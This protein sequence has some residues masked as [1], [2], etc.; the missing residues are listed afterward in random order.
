MRT[1]TR[2]AFTLSIA[3]AL[4]LADGAE[5]AAARWWQAVETDS[6]QAAL[7]EV[8]GP[9][10]DVTW[11]VPTQ[12]KQLKYAVQRD[13]ILGRDVLAV[14]G[15]RSMLLKGRTVYDS[16]AEVRCLVRLV[17]TEKRPSVACT[18]NVA[19]DMD[20]PRDPGI[21]LVLQAR[22]NSHFVTVSAFLPYK[23][24]S[25]R[26]NLKPYD[27]ISPALPQSI[28]L[29][30]EKD[31][32]DATA[33]EDKWIRVKCQTGADWVRVWVDDRLLVNVTEAQ[34]KVAREQHRE[35]ELVKITA[36]ED[37][38]SRT[39][40]LAAFKGQKLNK[41]V[42]PT[43]G[44]VQATLSPGSRLANLTVGPLPRSF[45]R[46]ETVALSGY[47]R[48]REL[49]G[50]KNT[51][52]AEGALPFGETVTVRGIPF[53][54]AD[55]SVT[56]GADHIDVGRSFLRQA[57]MQG[58]FP[59][60]L[61]RF[62]GAFYVDPTRIQLHLPN[63][64]YDSMYVVAAFDEERDSIPLLSA[65]FY[66]PSAGF[67]RVFEATVPSYRTERAN[68]DA[69]PVRLEDGRRAN[70]WLV[71]IPLDPA[72]LASFSDLGVLGLELTKKVRQYRSYPDPYIYGWHQGG[73]P[74]GV[75]V[76][77][78]TL[79][80]P[81]VHLT[82][83][84][85]PFGHVWPAG[86]RATYEVRLEN[87]TAEA[88]P[89]VPNAETTSYDGTETTK[90]SRTLTV[91]PNR[92]ARQRLYF[93]VK[94]FGIHTL[95]VTMKHGRKA[96]TEQRNFAHLAPD[97]RSVR[98]EPGKG[99][100]FGFWSYA[101]G[102]HTPPAK[103][104]FRV[105][106][107]A[108]A[109][110]YVHS[111]KV[112]EETQK[113]IFD[114]HNFQFG[115]SA[116]PIKPQWAWAADEKLDMDQYAAYATDAVDRIRKRQGDSPNIV[117]FF[118]EPHISQRVTAGNC[119]T[120]W[121]EK[122][123]EYTDD[124]RRHLRLFFNTAKAAAEGVHR[125]WPDAK[126][127]IPWGDPLFVLPL[128]RAGFP[129][130][131][132]DGS[133]LDMIG[134]ERL[135]EQQLHQ[136]STHRLYILREE[137]RK[138]GMDNPF[139]PYVE[140]IFVPTEPGACTWE[141]QAVRYHRW[142]L[143]SLAYGITHFFSGWFAFDCGD[144]YGAEH[145]GGCGIQRRIPYA[146]AKPAYAHFATMTRM[147]D[148][149]TF[150][151]WIP[152]GSLTTYCLRFSRAKGGPVYALWTLRGRRPVTLKLAKDG[153]VAVID[154]MDN[155]VKVASR[156][157]AVTVM[158]GASPV[159]VANAGDVQSAQVGKPDHRD[160]AAWSRA[161][162]QQTWHSGPASRD[163]PIQ[164]EIKLAS[165]GDG[166]WEIQPAERD[167][168]YET[169]NFDTMRY[170]GKMTAKLVGDPDRPGKHFATRLEKQATERKL[171][172]W[173]TVI[174]PK[175]PVI[176]PG[177]ARH[178]CLWMR[179]HSDWGR[180][181]YCLR[182]AKGE[183]WVSVGTRDQWNCDDVH[184]WSCFNFDGWRYVHF[185]LP[186]HT[187][188]DCF[189]EYGT[190]WWRYSGG[191]A[192]VDLPLRIE[193]IIVERRTHVLYVNDI[194]P[195]DPSDVLLSDLFAEYETPFDATQEAVAL[196][197]LRMKLPKPPDTLPNPI[198][199]M[200]ADSPLA[201]TKL[202]R[203]T[204]PDWGYDGTRCHVHFDEVD[205]ATQYQVWV[206]ARKDGRGAVRMARMSESGQLL[207]GLR[208]ATPFCLWVTYTDAGK[209]Q[210]KPTNCLAIELVD[211]FGQK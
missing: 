115:P 82:I 38:K 161:R 180:V 49:L 109:R 190:T 167:E 95:R 52:V 99:P 74:S 50:K 158:T 187:A 186:S 32:A 77:A 63:A 114:R 13:E 67:A 92:V 85:M 137:Y 182:D 6:A 148:R 24:I 37:V 61:H 16:G 5:P 174:R 117:T 163:I 157:G 195:T 211:A 59:S 172:P 191:D 193:K 151:R 8:L 4:S 47:V 178:L 175:K 54:F 123:Y 10:A 103:D 70:L 165:L 66:R 33:V 202:H 48:D 25:V 31:M 131:L 94:K 160:A 209:K 23:R 79:R 138:F 122:P 201:P 73:L 192:I 136:Q 113:T 135:P 65:S 22:H 105:M 120:Y 110:G 173:Y 179:A 194:Q 154:S 62:A 91:P 12:T 78:V 60:R 198:K 204:D 46:Y 71:E 75:H 111:R 128:L 118:P 96:W 15:P 14:D 171:M 106:A 210:S 87:R 28:R 139:L 100:M 147:L 101:G 207:R 181:V 150:D 196:N 35:R 116:W 36:I 104:Q 107:M 42:L 119:P 156:G 43:S 199:D 86:Q 30:L 197:R 166:S 39:A 183:R 112:D 26:Y 142:S 170:H 188:Y 185:E 162:N 98:W 56:G 90:Q 45:G 169:N 20:N 176:I 130:H 88:Q 11:A 206:S 126:I 18:L 205:G 69:L 57:N 200:T 93:R 140:G 76:Y 127:L 51:A 89:V 84:P 27:V 155:A 40:K 53:R 19:K 21:R 68:A 125:E 203:V 58:Y 102:H 189:R 184:S 153:A 81:E 124:E 149:S 132:I 2:H 7:R 145:Y 143:I 168:S 108:G 141:G 134:F 41:K 64:R 3:V 146:D 152:T 133:G 177:K 83:A 164:K 80:R 159:Y 44:H 97:T 208:P 121:G 144:Y 9:G 34:L 1:P 55:P 29:P 129:R 17:P 72:A